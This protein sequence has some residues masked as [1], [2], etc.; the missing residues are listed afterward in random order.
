[1]PSLSALLVDGSL[2]PWHK[3]REKK[4]K[5]GKKKKGT[6]P[7]VAEAMNDSFALMMRQQK[8]RG[9]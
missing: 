8:K 2:I 1:L 5:R 3:E 9:R 7:T 4:G 6:G